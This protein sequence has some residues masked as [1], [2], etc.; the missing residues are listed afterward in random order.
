MSNGKERNEAMR[1]II[2][3][4]SLLMLVMS[5]PLTGAEKLET[6]E[7]VRKFRPI[8]KEGTDTILYKKIVYGIDCRFDAK[9]EIVEDSV[10]KMD[11]W[12]VYDKDEALKIE[13][14]SWNEIDSQRVNLYGDFARRENL[15]V[16]YKGRGVKVDVSNIGGY[17]TDWGF[18]RGKALYLD[19]YRLQNQK[20]FFAFDYDFK[21]GIFERNLSLGSKNFWLGRLSFDLSSEGIIGSDDVMR[22]GTESSLNIA[23]TSYS[24]MA[25]LIYRAELYFGGQLETIMNRDEDK[26]F[27]VLGKRY[28]FGL[29]AE[30][31]L[32]NYPIYWVHTHNGYVRRAMPLTVSLRYLPVAGASLGYSLLS[33]WEVGAEYELAFSPYLIL[34]GEWGYSKFRD[35]PDGMDC[36]ASYVSLTV[37]QDIDILK[38]HIW[39][40]KLIFGSEDDI[41]GKNF[42][43]Y[44][45]TEGQKPPLFED[46][47]ESS[48]GLSMY[49]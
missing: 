1:R 42:I 13:R 35:V 10:L 30:I 26:L 47:R 20:S 46:I 28:E 7:L 44:R 24:Y 16:K 5:L 4:L 22:N 15:L 17:E 19:M 6:A 37:A 36:D 14:I 23:L 25:G 34:Q 31:P 29:E 18:G 41:R 38:N 40:L 8:Y 21:V 48:F 45:V 9:S 3:F 32:T 43:F 33:R 12:R 49:F 2:I 11:N 27:D 39:F